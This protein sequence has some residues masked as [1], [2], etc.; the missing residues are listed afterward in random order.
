VDAI[1]GEGLGL[2]FRQGLA[3]ADA[4]EAGDLEKYQSAHRWLARRPHFMSRLLLLLDG[5]VAVA[6]AGSARFGKGPSFDHRT[7]DGTLAGYFSPVSG[8]RRGAI[9]MAAR[10]CIRFLTLSKEG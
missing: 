4:L 2:S 8:G 9:S 3:L 7:V 6:K 1:T 10:Y 5:C